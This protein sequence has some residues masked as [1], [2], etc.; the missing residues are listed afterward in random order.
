MKL[1]NKDIEPVL[2]TLMVFKDEK[3]AGG[4]L[5]E[6]ITLGL[7]RKLQKIRTEILKKY[8][9]F[10]KDLEDAQ[11]EGEKEELLEEEFEI[12]CEPASMALI[13]NIQTANN[14]DMDVVEKFAI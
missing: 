2:I 4:L 5:T 1:K 8:E 7:R 12:S 3:P 6:N 13:E 9:E 11:K 10:K 14:Y